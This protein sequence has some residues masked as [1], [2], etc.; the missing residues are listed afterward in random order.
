MWE[1]GTSAIRLI[2]SQGSVAMYFGFS[3]R[4]C[5]QSF[6][7]VLC[8]YIMKRKT[9]D[10]DITDVQWSLL[11]P[12]LPLA[13]PGGR[14]RSVNLREI[15]NALF[16]VCRTGCSWRL[17][18]HEF[19]PWQT[20]YKY[21]RRWQ[22]DGTWERVHAVLREQVREQEDREATPSAAVLDS[23]SVKTTEKGGLAGLMG[24][25]R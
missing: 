18:P 22:Q 21:F 15:L 16:Y 3:L 7:F 10:T 20:V 6:R 24:A 25:K 1:F 14:P 12:L 5:F 11:E 19:P 9:Y 17:L 13:K 4:G 23:Q 8:C 2:Y